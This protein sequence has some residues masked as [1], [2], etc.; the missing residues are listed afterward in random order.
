MSLPSISGLIAAAAFDAGRVVRAACDGRTATRATALALGLLLAASA[1]DLRF[2]SAAEAQTLTKSQ[3][4]ALDAYNNAL[5]QFKSV[6]SQR[7]AQI[8]SNQPLP[9]LPGQA[10][11]LARNNM[12]S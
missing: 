5:A 8:N 9:N 12:I 4:D 6:L 2:I 1:S 11:Y 3:S 7:R 10:I